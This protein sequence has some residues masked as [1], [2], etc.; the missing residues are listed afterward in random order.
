MHA[1]HEFPHQ[2]AFSVHGIMALGR[3]Q[4]MI[5]SMS[6]PAHLSDRGEF[7]EC[8]AEEFA[9]F[10]LLRLQSSVMSAAATCK[11]AGPALLL[12]CGSLAQEDTV[13]ARE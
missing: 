13:S 12:V 1:T 5:T 11:V 2:P 8:P 6:K 10:V 7:T 4:H 3:E 9:A